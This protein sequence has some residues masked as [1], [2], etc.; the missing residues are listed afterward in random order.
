MFVALAFLDLSGLLPATAL[1]LE[2]AAGLALCAAA[3]SMVRASLPH[4]EPAPLAVV[5]QLPVQRTADLREVHP[6]A[7]ERRV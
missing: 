1:V 2:P 5:L 3:L 4:R 7:A 6:E